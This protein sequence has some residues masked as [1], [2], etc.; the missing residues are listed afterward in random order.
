MLEAV[1]EAQERRGEQVIPLAEARDVHASLRMFG[2]PTRP[3]LID[4][5]H[6]RHILNTHPEVSA[7]DIAALPQLLRRPRAVLAN[8]GEDGK[9]K[10]GIRVVVD[11]RDEAGNPLLVALEPV[12]MSR[13]R[14]EVR[15]GEPGFG[16]ALRVT[17]V[18]TLFGWDASGQKMLDAMRQG[19]VHYLS[20]ESVARMKALLSTAPIA[21]QSPGG[22]H[23]TPA[24]VPGAGRGRV[25]TTA[26]EAADTQQKHDSTPARFYSDAAVAAF[27]QERKA[28]ALR[29]FES[30][31][32]I[33]GG[34]PYAPLKLFGNHVVV[35]MA[36]AYVEAERNGD[37]A[38]YFVAFRE[39]KR[40]AHRLASEI[41]PKFEGG[42]S[43]SFERSTAQIL[44]RE[45][46]VVDLPQVGAEP[47]RTVRYRE[48][49]QERDA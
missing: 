39:T 24:S 40:E 3:V 2:S 11:A 27:E 35:G 41:A 42:H 20:Q 12:R 7:E 19:E 26:T 9:P 16:D 28:K 33:G 5:G 44:E 17:G 38:H 22:G 13:A 37:P 47:S 48:Q 29:R 10:P 25:S 45:E 21:A 46:V 8:R 23:D 49:E 36:R 18:S 4:A 14:G 34:V 32:K 31:F 43:A 1:R 30:L 6:V 15:T